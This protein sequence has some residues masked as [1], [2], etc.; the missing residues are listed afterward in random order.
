MAELCKV[1]AVQRLLVALSRAGRL[2]RFDE[3]D[4]RKLS[5]RADVRS[6]DPHVLALAV[7]SGARTLVTSDGDLTTDFRNP[8]IIHGPRGSV[9]QH[10]AKHGHLLRHTP[11]SCGVKR[12]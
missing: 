12:K 5:H 2:R 11:K 10:P 1:G 4:E 6:N 9:Y 7:A 3:L 8:K